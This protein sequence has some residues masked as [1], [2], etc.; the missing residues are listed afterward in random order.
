[1]N[2]FKSFW[3]GLTEPHAVPVRAPR[4][5]MN[6]FTPRAQEVLVL[7]RKEADHLNHNFVGTEHVLL[8]LISLGQGTGFAAPEK[9]GA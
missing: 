8:G 5:V 3:K 9:D 4:E 7:A 1:V 2:W 6:N